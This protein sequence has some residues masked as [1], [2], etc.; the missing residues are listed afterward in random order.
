MTSGSEVLIRN[1]VS[2][3]LSSFLRSVGPRARAENES[4]VCALYSSSELTKVAIKYFGLTERN[5][6][7]PLRFLISLSFV[8]N[9][10]RFGGFGQEWPFPDLII[11]PSQRW[12]VRKGREGISN[13]YPLFVFRINQGRYQVLWFNGKKYI[14]TIEIPDLTIVRQE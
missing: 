1:D 14:P 4:P 11:I 9:D 5:I 12:A 3:T 7:L 2:L 13:L 10:E 6:P 8:R